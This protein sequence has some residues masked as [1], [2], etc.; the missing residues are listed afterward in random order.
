MS[1]IIGKGY[2]RQKEH[3]SL[4]DFIR[5]IVSMFVTTYERTPR[6]IVCHESVADEVKNVFT[7]TVVVAKVNQNLFII[8]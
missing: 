8:M 7:S 4:P 1:D 6:A 5:Y 2:Y 3:R